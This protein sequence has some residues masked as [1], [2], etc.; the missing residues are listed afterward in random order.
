MADISDVENTLVSL[1]AELLGL[2]SLYAAGSIVSSA[3][4]GAS[5]KVYRGWPERGALDADLANGV[6]NVSVFPP[7]AM[8]RRLPGHLFQWKQSPTVATP[9]L[10][11]SVSGNVVTFGGTSGANQVVGVCIV[12]GENTGVPYAY[13]L[14]ATDTP[15]TVAAAL[16]ALV[17][18]ASASGAV[19]T[20]PSGNPIQAAVAADQQAW[21]ETRRQEHAVWICIWS[22][23]SLLRDLFAGAIDGGIANMQDQ[24]GRQTVQ[25]A[26]PDGSDA[27]IH[28]SSS[29]TDDAP[30]Q[31]NLWRRD[32]RYLV[33]FPTTLLQMQPA[34]LFAG[35]NLTTTAQNGTTT[36]SPGWLQP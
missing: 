27:L 34:V 32:L 23:T 8:V 28:Y 20:M 1:V 21:L 22:P 29:K 30:E 12:T 25:F 33:N 17:P 35:V 13:R 6:T 15:A 16:A 9:S 3:A 2:G 11:V 19:L 24:W 26:L 5:C 31:A 14:L 10:T 7:P 4:V 18:G 36:S